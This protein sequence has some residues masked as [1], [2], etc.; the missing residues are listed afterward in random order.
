MLW[1]F[2]LGR[3]L[4]TVALV[5]GVLTVTDWLRLGAAG[6]R[7]GRIVLWSLVAGLVFGSLT[8]YHL[9]RRGCPR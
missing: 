6:I 4:Q 3:L 7:P 9:R 8:T 5:G 2:F 1:Q